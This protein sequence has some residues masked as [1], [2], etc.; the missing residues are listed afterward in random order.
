M[1]GLGA[2]GGEFSSFFLSLLP[3]GSDERGVLEIWSIPVTK[4]NT[5]T[6]L[7]SRYENQCIA[8]AQIEYMKINALLL[9]KLNIVR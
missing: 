8:I 2:V 3:I 7:S 9:H 4:C 1:V 5:C 6:S